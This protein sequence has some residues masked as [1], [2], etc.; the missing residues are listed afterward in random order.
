[1]AFT[2]LTCNMGTYGLA[3]NTRDMGGNIYLNVIIMSVVEFVFTFSVIFTAKWIGRRPTLIGYQI[4]AFVC[5]FVAVGL[6]ISNVNKILE[7]VVGAVGRASVMSSWYIAYLL[8]AELFPTLVRTIANGSCSVAGRI[9]GI[10]APQV[11]FLNNVHPALP[12]CVYG[13]FILVS[14]LLSFFLLPETKDT[15]LPDVLPPRVGCCTHPEPAE[16]M[17]RKTKRS[18]N[19]IVLSYKADH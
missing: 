17:G 5:L 12:G 3:M 15:P 18:E 7:G 13:V 2:W 14:T 8:T 19:V 1:M 10:L 9:G 11:A 16:E 6:N 4:I